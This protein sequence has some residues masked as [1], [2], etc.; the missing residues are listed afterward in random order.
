MAGKKKRARRGSGGQ[1]AFCPTIRVKC[2]RKH[3][4]ASGDYAPAGSRVRSKLAKF[5]AAKARI[6]KSLRGFGNVHP[7]SEMTSLPTAKAIATK[8]AHAAANEAKCTVSMGGKSWRLKG[9]AAGKKVA[10]LMRAQRSG[11]CCNPK[12]SRG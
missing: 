11:G 4:P 2:S 7:Q 5:K 1:R 8:V 10:E 3:A 12:V 9:A 6:L